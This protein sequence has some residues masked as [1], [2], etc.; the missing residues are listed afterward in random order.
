MKNRTAII[1]AALSL[2][3]SFTLVDPLKIASGVYDTGPYTEIQNELNKSTTTGVLVIASYNDYYKF[4]VFNYLRNILGNRLAYHGERVVELGYNEVLSQASLGEPSFIQYLYSQEISHLIIPMATVETGVVFHRWSSHGTINL[5]LT[6]PAYTQV[7]RS[8]GNFPLA[9]YEVNFP[10]GLKNVE[11]PTYSLEWSGVREEFHQL[12]RV[13]EED[14]NVRYWRQ[15]EE[16][17][18]TAWVFNREQIKVTFN[19]ESYPDQQF[20]IEFQFV[21][22]YG[23]NA[24]RQELRISHNLKTEVVELNAN[25][26]T[27][28]Q[29]VIKHGQTIEIEEL[30]G[31][32]Q[33]FTFAPEDQD[34]RE[35]CYGLRNVAVQVLS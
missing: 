8:G 11:S 1:T 4:P 17:I 35:F 20:L 22:A 32:P 29:L 21:A 33:G 12:L 7:R 10:E 23:D 16:R 24:P 6:S 34:I 27:T 13:I 5:D 9:L 15:Y 25:E 2:L 31:C 19:A 26:I 30:L 14:Y 28:I 3:L 18:D